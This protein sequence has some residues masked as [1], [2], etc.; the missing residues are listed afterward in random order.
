M[1]PPLFSFTTS[2]PVLKIYTRL[3][4]YVVLTGIE[5]T[6]IRCVGLFCVCGCVSYVLVLL[7]Y[8]MSHFARP[9]LY[10][11]LMF[12]GLNNLGATWQYVAT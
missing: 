3:L 4:L 8:F 9:P 11:M 5:T 10:L 1:T 12:P 6:L 2:N 7:S